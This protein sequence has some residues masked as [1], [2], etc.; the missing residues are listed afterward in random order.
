MGAWLGHPD[1]EAMQNVP[2]MAV[3][4]LLH[5]VFLELHEDESDG[6]EYRPFPPPR[7]AVA[8]EIDPYSG[9]LARE[10]EPSQVTW[11]VRGTEPRDYSNVFRDFAVDRRTGTLAGPNTPAEAVVFRRYPVFPPEYATWAAERGFLP[12]ASPVDL[13]REASVLISYPPD[14]ARFVIDP[15]IPRSF[16]SIAL[17]ATVQPRI[18]ELVWM[19]NGEEYERV[20]F[21]YRTRLSLEPGEYEIYASF[22]E[23]FVRS[24]A[25][26][27]RV[28]DQDERPDPVVSLR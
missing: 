13:P 21:P 22:G 16:Q 14:G 28:R 6:L 3:A 20:G 4:E 27:I 9:L 23:A 15:D 2:G 26:R 10:G 11:F 19:V 17:R 24:P 1:N 8:L 18:R 25:V 7:N 5:E 12:P